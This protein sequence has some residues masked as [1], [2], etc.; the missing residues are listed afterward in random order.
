M[1]ISQ[2]ALDNTP[3]GFLHRKDRLA[4]QEK[5]D[6]LESKIRAEEASIRMFVETLGYP[7]VREAENDYW[8]AKHNLD[9]VRRA[10]DLW[11]GKSSSQQP[12]HPSILKELQESINKSVGQKR[13]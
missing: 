10:Q 12:E 3:K 1:T 13:S 9:Q 2:L 7:S 4:L 6:E 8:R 5:I 11:D